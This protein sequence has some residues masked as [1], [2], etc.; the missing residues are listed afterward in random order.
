[1]N[2]TGISDALQLQP[3]QF[4]Y[5][6]DAIYILN[7]PV[8]KKHRRSSRNIL[9]KIDDN[10]LANDLID[11]IENCTTRYLFPRHQKFSR[12]I[13]HE[14]HTSRSNVYR[15]VNAIDPCLWPHGLRALRASHLVSERGFN[16]FELTR[17]FNW[18]SSNMALH[19]TQ[20]QSMAEVLGIKQIPT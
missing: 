12:K 11:M 9:I 8:L 17:W 6:E 5:N 13:L 1:M 15:K 7:V 20:S 19:Y 2:T 3:Y 18:R 4:R 16:V 14:L 10:P